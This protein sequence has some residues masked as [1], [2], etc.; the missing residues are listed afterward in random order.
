[1]QDSKMTQVSYK[2]NVWL[3]LWERGVCMDGG[4]VEVEWIR[5]EVFF[6]E[7]V[8]WSSRNLW[9]TISADVK[10]NIKQQEIKD[11]VAVS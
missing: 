2:N 9:K 6:S 11:L 8:E 10:A 3:K 7:N 5:W 1:M 4:E